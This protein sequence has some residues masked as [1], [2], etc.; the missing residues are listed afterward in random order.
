MNNSANNKLEKFAVQSDSFVDISDEEFEALSSLVYN[1][2]G[3][4]LTEKKKNLLKA[5]L[6]KILRRRGIK[7]FS[8]YYEKAK[9]DK[10][11]Q[12]LSELAT[13]ISTNYTYFYRENAHFDFFKDKVLPY[14]E[15]KFEKES[16]K[17]LRIWSA[18]CSSGEEPYMLVML[19]MEYFGD[20]YKY[21]DAGVLA[22]DISENALSYAKK[23]VYPEDRLKK[24]PSVYKK[25]Y[26]RRVSE[27]SWEV[28]D[29]VKKEVL[30]RRFNLMNEKF[31]FKKPFHT[32]FCRNVMIY[33]DDPTK[34][35]LVQKFY[36][37]LESG[38]FFFIGHSETLNRIPG[39]R[40]KYIMPAL[41]RKP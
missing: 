36:D 12:I 10:S 18:G 28:V 26:F 37:S 9:T 23:G 5:R 3:I 6:Q 15:K 40:F 7:T 35:A 31:P 16:R 39:C 25:K 1:T 20:Q 30:F 22:T 11:G 4:H 29:F 17:D 2:I 33:F 24:L 32:I 27:D 13:S 34:A 19:M 14:L 21:Y 38:G 8:E 41:Y